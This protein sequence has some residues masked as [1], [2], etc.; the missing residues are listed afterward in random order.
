MKSKINHI[1]MISLLLLPIFF[2]LILSLFPARV[3]ADRCRHCKGK[4]QDCPGRNAKSSEESPKKE[5]ASKQKKGE[6]ESK[7][8]E[9]ENNAKKVD[10][11][12]KSKNDKNTTSNQE[13]DPAQGDESGNRTGEKEDNSKEEIIEEEEIAVTPNKTK[14]TGRKKV[15]LKSGKEKKKTSQQKSD[16]KKQNMDD[17][18][19]DPIVVTA[20][21]NKRTIKDVPV[22]TEVIGSKKMEQKG[23]KN[24]YEAIDNEVGLQVDNMCSICNARGIKISGMPNRYTLYLVDGMP[25]YSSLGTTYALSGIPV[26]LIKQ[27]EIVKGGSSVLYGSNAVAGVVNVI[28][29]KPNKNF[30]LINFSYGNYGKIHLSAVASAKKKNLFGK[31]TQGGIIGFANHEQMNSIDQNND[32]ITE[33][34]AYTRSFV[35]ATFFTYP[36]SF[37]DLIFRTSLMNEQRQGGGKGEFLGVITDWDPENQT[38]KRAIS[39]SILTNRFEN[40]LKIS[41]YGKNITANIDAAFVF[42]KQD[43]DYEGEYYFGKQ[44]I[45]YANPYLNW[46]AGDNYDLLI[47]GSYRQEKLEENLAVSEY[48]YKQTGIFAQGNFH[49]KKKFELLHGV[50]YDYHNVFGSVFTPRLAA[51]F[52]PSKYFTTRLSMGTGFRAPTTFY[53]YNHGVHPT[54]YSIHMDAEDPEKS[55]GGNLSFTLSK[56]LRSTLTVELGYNQIENAIFMEKNEDGSVVTVGNSDEKFSVFSLESSLNTKLSKLFV[57]SLGYGYYK[58]KDDGGVLATAPASQRFTASMTFAWKRFELS[59]DGKLMAPMNL[60]SVYG[61]GYNPIAGANLDQLLTGTDG[62]DTNSQKLAESPWWGLVNLNMHFHINPRVKAYIEVNNL[63]DYHQNDKETPVYFPA[64][65]SGCE[66]SPLDVVYIW[67]PLQGRTF[68]GGLKIK[69]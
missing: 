43:S 31:G 32:G 17:E 18:E 9:K 27:L 44:H 34:A 15:K 1:H 62:A 7:K 8:A 10:N 58:Y 37:M 41:F 28:T 12:P 47:G 48:N 25:L 2:V 33:M 14:F 6:E 55:M 68:M 5:N 67:G 49:L 36:L 23:A 38:G 29:K 54:G 21:R 69:L 19:E 60:T 51:K 26:G 63:L 22:K 64:G 16:K 39:E 11:K 66:P 4:C 24:V 65:C 46:K 3:Q 35:G 20:T 13:G 56:I 40:T 61:H 57:F 50:R 30:N 59:L 53:E 42:H 45:F 52:S